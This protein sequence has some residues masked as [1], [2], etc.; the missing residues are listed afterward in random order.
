MSAIRGQMINKQIVFVYVQLYY[1]KVNNM[2]YFYDHV[3]I[4]YQF[5]EIGRVVIINT[6]VQ[7][8]NRNDLNIHSYPVVEL[9]L[10]SWSS[11]SAFSISFPPYQSPACAIPPVLLRCDYGTSLSEFSLILCGTAV[12]F[13]QEMPHPSGIV[14]G[15]VP[16]FVE[17]RML[18]QLRF[19]TA[20]LPC[21]LEPGIAYRAY[22][23]KQPIGIALSAVGSFPFLELKCTFGL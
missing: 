17:V 23:R 13:A 1:F 3:C 4:S 18:P 14:S 12:P 7:I 9:R 19:I 15:S 6:V 16:D 22:I 10:K 8:K 21:A 11:D 20:P 2:Q 5:S